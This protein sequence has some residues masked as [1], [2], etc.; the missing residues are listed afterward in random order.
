MPAVR[1]D[2]RPPAQGAVSPLQPQ[3]RLALCAAGEIWGG[4]ERFVVTTAT[5][6]RTS[7]ID[8]L[9]VLFHDELLARMLRERGLRV[10]VL[11]PLAKYDGRIVGEMR[12]LLR[13]HGVNVLHVHG[14]KAT[15]IGALATR[16]LGIKVVK[17][18]HGLL[19]PFP[20]WKALWS[21]SR[22]SV[23]TVV[24]RAA[25]RFLTDARVFV[26]TD[27]KRHLVSEDD[28][29]AHRVIYNGIDPADLSGGVPDRADTSRFDIGI[30]GRVDKVKGHEVLLRAFAR[31]RHLP[32][33]RLHVLGTGPL[34]ERCRQLSEDIGV[35]DVVHFHGFDPAV[36]ARM[37]TLDLLVIPSL[38][39]GL[40]YV[41]L[42]AMYLKVPVVASRVG[43]MP[44]VLERDDC[45]VLVSANDPAPLAAAIERL[46]HDRPLRRS[47]AERAF[48]VVRRQYL[49][50]RMVR[51]YGELYQQLL[52]S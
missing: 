1:L 27:I 17:T 31:L 32:S 37:A 9:I 4:V 28:S 35:S 40:P 36:H 7:G 3:V 29:P 11:G 23:T 45:G 5:A 39:E 52:V 41:L 8:P 20:G 12:R 26:S 2:D 22:L 42:E 30:V 19:E 18:E 50:D 14:Y 48:T 49:A 34:E 44:E 6:L 10:Q 47:L 43:G 15:I 51:Q 24:E 21:H 13:E 46:Y 16:G 38:R 33:L 25:S